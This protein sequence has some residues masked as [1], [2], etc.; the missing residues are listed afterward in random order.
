[1]VLVATY[2]EPPTRSRAS[3]R[4]RYHS[5]MES[6]IAFGDGADV[7]SPGSRG[8]DDRS[9]LQRMSSLHGLNGLRSNSPTRRPFNLFEAPRQT[10]PATTGWQSPPRN[11]MSASGELTDQYGNR[12]SRR[13]KSPGRFLDFQSSATPA[14]E[15]NDAMAARAYRRKR[16]PEASARHYSSDIFH[17][18]RFNEPEQQPVLA[19]NVWDEN[20][21]VAYRRRKSP[22]REEGSVG[23]NGQLLPNGSGAY[24]EGLA[25]SPAAGPPS[26]GSPLPR[27]RSAGAAGLYAVNRGGQDAPAGQRA[28]VWMPLSWTGDVE[29]AQ[30]PS[31]QAYMS[32]MYGSKH[33][34]LQ[35]R[36]PSPRGLGRSRSDFPEPRTPGEHARTPYRSPSPMGDAWLFAA[37]EKLR[38]WKEFKEQHREVLDKMRERDPP[39]GS[40]TV[41]RLGLRS[42]KAEPLERLMCHAAH[43]SNRVPERR[44][45]FRCPVRAPQ[46]ALANPHPRDRKIESTKTTHSVASPRRLQSR[47]SRTSACSTRSRLSR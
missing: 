35:S 12:C 21:A 8:R 13:G 45:D 33:S 47:T 14:L 9:S 41:P 17:R 39:A 11:Q 42:P 46:Q 20:F 4:E 18:E 26:R 15:S 6:K 27:S 32:H 24:R 1:M 16:S 10:E 34:P 19:S 3:S 30:T 40:P 7:R 44:R 23:C 29:R 2:A 38:Q 25:G 31:R 36:S 43:P 37:A 5:H 22:D 28:K